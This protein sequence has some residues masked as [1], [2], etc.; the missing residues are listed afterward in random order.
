MSNMLKPGRKASSLNASGSVAAREPWGAVMDAGP[1]E[2]VRPRA[3]ETDERPAA[4]EG[5]G[6][7]ESV[8]ASAAPLASVV[9]TAASS[10]GRLA[11]WACTTATLT[12]DSGGLASPVALA[13]IADTRA[14]ARS[15]AVPSRSAGAEAGAASAGEATAD[16]GRG[17]PHSPQKRLPSGH[18]E[19]HSRLSQVQSAIATRGSGGA[20]NGRGVTQPQDTRH[21]GLQSDSLNANA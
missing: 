14:E 3:L 11:E 9:V 8:A 7:T 18:V 13:G 1:P 12:S 19:P 2:C 16:L 17:R 6:A 4:V 20:A 10:T 21:R 5:A 15:A